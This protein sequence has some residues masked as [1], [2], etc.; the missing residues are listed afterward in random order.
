[1]ISFFRDHDTRQHL[2][3]TDT[4]YSANHSSSAMPNRAHTTKMRTNDI[5]LKRPMKY[6]THQTKDGLAKVASKYSLSLKKTNPLSPSNSQAGHSFIQT[7]KAEKT[8]KKRTILTGVQTAELSST[9][10][11]RATTGTLP[12]LKSC[13]NLPQNNMGT[14]AKCGTT[15]AGKTL[16]EDTTTKEVKGHP[17]TSAQK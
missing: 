12:P 9:K 10:I 1:M 15:S 2:L 13:K 7:C 17:V 6:Y 14:S 8:T 11:H 4:Q 3:E 5:P 16:N